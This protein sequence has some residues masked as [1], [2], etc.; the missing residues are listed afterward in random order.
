M[1]LE[2]R[3]FATLAA[4]LLT[5]AAGCR[6]SPPEPSRLELSCAVGFSGPNPVLT[7][8]GR[9]RSAAAATEPPI[10]VTL[11]TWPAPVT[12]TLAG[13][14]WVGAGEFRPS[15]LRVGMSLA[16]EATIDGVPSPTT[17]QVQPGLP[18]FNA[19]LT[20]TTTGADL[21]WSVVP[22][23]S[24]YRWSLRAGLGGAVVASGNTLGTSAQ[25]IATLDA[26]TPYLA[27]VGAYALTGAEST[28]PSPLP[29]PS[30]AFSRV[31][32]TAGRSGGDG[33]SA[34]QF[35]APGDFIGG[36]LSV[37]FPG[38]A[39]GE[40]LAV[41]LLNADGVDRATATVGVIGTG[42]P[43]LAQV[44]PH[45]AL[46]QG[47]GA[48][49][50][51]RPLELSGARGG[52]ALVTALREETISRLRDGRLQRERSRPAPRGA[53]AAAAATAALAPSRSFCQ[54]RWS[55]TGTKPYWQSATLAFETAHA[56]FYYADE[57]KAGIDTAVAT[58]ATVVPAG[59][60]PFWG[61]LGATF[62]AKVYPALSTYFGPMSDV[63][64]NGKVIFLL[65]NLGSQDGNYTMGYF[66][67]GDLELPQVSSVTCPN[68]AA[69]NRADML[70]LMDPGNF[71]IFANP[72]GNYAA[73]LE[74]MV[75]SEYPSV[76]AHELQHDVNYNARCPAGAA[77]GPDEETWLN[78]GLSMLSSTVAGFGL[79]DARGRA[80]VRAYQGELDSATGLPYHR[81]YSLTIWEQSPDGNYAGVEAYTQYLLDQ[82]SPSVIRSLES[83]DLAGKANVEAATGVPWEV[84]FARFATALVFSNEDRSEPHGTIGLVT[85]A[86]NQ[87][88]QP[89][90]NFLGA[91][92][93][94]DY[95]PWH[96]YTGF[97]TSGGV[98]LPTPRLAYVAYLP[99]A[100]SATVPLRRDGWTALATGQGSG[101]PA[102]I[103]VQS[104]ASVPP[105]V[106]VVK[107]TGA[108]P[109]YRPIGAACP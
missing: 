91:G 83:R 9:A 13:A 49:V 52:E 88:A 3:R 33:T 65:A 44:T 39:A 28:L 1:L 42:L 51:D 77:C 53:L 107:Y 20:R 93:P 31:G 35:F 59:V 70:Y 37:G 101:G 79:H 86:G 6:S 97:C 109:N 99:L 36:T 48:P 32:F 94:D 78:E 54:F 47:P 84:G 7:V 72:T 24:I 38:L 30:T 40:R 105:H 76:M 43:S 103:T 11:Q 27:E 5:A 2:T 74:A 29:V 67:P 41:L 63:D 55:A 22:G 4:L 12:F 62:E 102:T 80:E 66:W 17:C 19:S 108:L 90:F 10:T 21:S 73:G 71:T 64:G 95:V 106:A 15:F 100:T 56:G 58:R 45:L 14:S 89:P 8:L 68:G 82:A 96:H 98:R 50:P 75:T 26:T 61:E 81:A 25:A 92:P 104:S 60:A 34:W 16:G 87:L 57:V 85:S 69:G 18:A 23:A 46:A